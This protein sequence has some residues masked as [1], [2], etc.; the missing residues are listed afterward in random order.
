M[1]RWFSAWVLALG[2]AV[3][4]VAAP[5]QPAQAD[6]IGERQ[7]LQMGDDAARQIEAQ[8]RLSGDSRKRRLVETIGQRIAAA[9][10]RPN[11]PW[12]FRV[13][14]TSEVN[15][16]SVPGYVYV[17]TGLMDFVGGDRDELAAVIAHEVAHTTRKHAVR[18]TEK[19]M[20]GSL[21]MQLLFKDKRSTASGLANVAANLALLGYSRKDEFEADR[22]GTEYLMQAGYDPNGMVRFFQKLRAREGKESRGLTTYFRSHPPTSDRIRKVQEYVAARR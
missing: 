16:F 5:P 22:V 11:L 1:R 20:I 2:V 4:L 13:L 12:K 8:Y 3:G 18:Q 14:D 17:N 21:A 9:S 6:L 19:S 15:A 7:E 10:S